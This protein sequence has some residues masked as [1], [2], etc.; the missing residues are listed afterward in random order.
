MK[1]LIKNLDKIREKYS[2]ANNLYEDL[3]N[4]TLSEGEVLEILL[5]IQNSE[6]DNLGFNLLNIK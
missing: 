5:G 1:F 2:T 6:N 4:R 3:T